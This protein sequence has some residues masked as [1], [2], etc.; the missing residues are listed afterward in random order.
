MDAL[1]IRETY[2]TPFSREDGVRYA[3]ANDEVLEVCRKFPGRFRAWARVQ[4]KLGRAAADEVRRCRDAGAAGVFLQPQADTFYIENCLDIFKIADV[5]GFPVMLH[6]DHRPNAHPQYWEG[7]FEKFHRVRF[8][9]A[10]GG[11]DHYMEAADIARRLDNVFLDTAAMPLE[12]TRQAVEAAGIGKVLF[13][14][15]APYSHAAL[16]KLKYELLAPGEAGLRGI[17]EENSR[18]FFL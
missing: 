15:D 13:C 7:V 1:G 6:T 10:H 2:L 3:E 16:E 5:G 14:S 18:R 17:F 9:L 11:K 12:R 8:L 4:P